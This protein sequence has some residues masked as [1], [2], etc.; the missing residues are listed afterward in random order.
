MTQTR[1]TTIVFAIRSPMGREDITPLCMRVHVILRTTRAEVALC[2]VRALAA[3]AVAINALAR[4]QLTARRLGRT[5][6]LRSV[7][8]DLCDLLTL[9]GLAEVLPLEAERQAEQREHPLGVEE[10]RELPDPPA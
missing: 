10:E 7:A 8:V 9:C 2:D 5:V 3:D 6:W 1:P 4:I